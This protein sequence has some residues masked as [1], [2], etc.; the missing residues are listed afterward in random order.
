M[1]MN[2][3]ARCLMKHKQDR[4]DVISNSSFFRFM[5]S[6]R[7]YLNF[8]WTSKMN[9]IWE[10]QELLFSR[11]VVWSDKQ[12]VLINFF[13]WN[14]SFPLLCFRCLRRFDLL[15]FAD[16]QEEYNIYHKGKQVTWTWTWKP[17]LISI[18][19]PLDFYGVWPIYCFSANSVNFGHYKR[20]TD[21]VGEKGSFQL[22]NKDLLIL[23]TAKS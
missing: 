9:G 1:K 21:F 4:K 15:T 6:C 11:I 10:I 7:C 23:Y 22:E 17:T 18:R 12:F 13:L 16:L 20:V 3:S 5:F 14:F 2:G 8:I 19:L